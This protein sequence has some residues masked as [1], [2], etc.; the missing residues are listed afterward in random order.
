MA[1]KVGTSEQY[2]SWDIWMQG[3]ADWWMTCH[4]RP[5]KTC[6]NKSWTTDRYS[7]YVLWQQN[8][9]LMCILCLYY[10]L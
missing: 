7:W 1:E 9:Y 5:T 8:L 6:G 10:N 4:Q 3:N 2:R